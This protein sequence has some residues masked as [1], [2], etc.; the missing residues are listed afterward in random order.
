M[1]SQLVISPLLE[2]QQS[3]GQRASDATLSAPP[4]APGD[5]AVALRRTT[6]L[7]SALAC[8][9]ACRDGILAADETLLSAAVLPGL[10]QPA[11]GGEADSALQSAA[12]SL[13]G[14]LCDARMAS[15]VGGGQDGAGLPPSSVMTSA[16]AAMLALCDGDSD[17]ATL[18]R[19]L[20]VKLQRGLSRAK[21]PV[22]QQLGSVLLDVAHVKAVIEG[23]DGAASEEVAEDAAPPDG[24]DDGHQQPMLWP[25][26]W[27]KPEETGLRV[28]ARQV[29]AF[30]TGLVKAELHYGLEAK[31]EDQSAGAKRPRPQPKSD[32]PGVAI[33]GGLVKVVNQ[34]GKFVLFSAVSVKIFVA[35]Y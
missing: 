23:E 15:S 24:A 19:D 6:L 9:P 21:Q 2:L 3:L 35:K 11:Q 22:M 20:S 8:H 13:L 25:R 7:L 12:L 34:L 18:A 5:S 26:G 17:V 31:A 30:G 1:W 28:L 14:N 33:A 16:V 29:G 27:R 32:A 10:R 4:T